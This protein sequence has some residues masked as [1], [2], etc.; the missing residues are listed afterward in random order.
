MFRQRCTGCNGKLYVEESEKIGT[1]ETCRGV[2]VKMVF[3]ES[4]YNP[5]NPEDV[6]EI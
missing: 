6:Y 2:S 1:C 3:S 4:V 5:P